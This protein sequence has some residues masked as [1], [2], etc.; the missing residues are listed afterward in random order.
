[1]GM[2]GGVNIYKTPLSKECLQEDCPLVNL[3][4]NF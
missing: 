4:I 1:M 2:A 3:I